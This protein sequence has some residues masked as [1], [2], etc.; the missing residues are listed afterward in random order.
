MKNETLLEDFKQSLTAA[1]KSKSTVEAYLRIAR[2]FVKHVGDGRL[3]RIGEAQTAAFFAGIKSTNTRGIRAVAVNQFVR[4]VLSRLPVPVAREVDAPRLPSVQTRKELA[5][6]QAWE[7]ERKTQEQEAEEQL[8]A[9][10]A[11]QLVNCYLHFK[12][13]IK[14]APD[15]L[16]ELYRLTAECEELIHTNLQVFM[17]LS[18]KGLNLGSAINER[19]QARQ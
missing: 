5:L 1:G 6:R 15:D 18:G 13:R 17:E 16:D 7:I 3:D 8:T 14:G 19:A 12:A 9:R 11:R 10:L 2:A 4:F